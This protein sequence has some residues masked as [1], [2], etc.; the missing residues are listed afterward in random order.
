[1][2]FDAEIVKGFLRAFA[3]GASLPIPT[4]Q[5]QALTP[6]DAGDGSRVE[7]DSLI[8]FMSDGPTL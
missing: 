1:V 8:T 6:A 5:L 2:Q 7:P 4:P 3:E